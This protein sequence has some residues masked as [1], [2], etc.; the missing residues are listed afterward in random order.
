MAG[1]Y[2]KTQQD[3]QA[4]GPFTTDQLKALAARGK[5]KPHHL[6]SKDQKKWY[7]VKN[8]RGLLAPQGAAAGAA[9]AA[10]P[11]LPQDSD[12]VEMAPAQAVPSDGEARAV[13]AARRVAP[14]RRRARK[15]PPVA[16]LTTLGC[17]LIVGVIVG[18][19]L[20]FGRG[21]SNGDAS[22]DEPAAPDK[23]GANK[24]APDKGGTTTKSAPVP[25]A[26][27]PPAT[28]PPATTPPA[29][30]PPA[31]TPPA[32]TP[33]ATTPPATTPPAT[34]PP[35]T[36]PPATTPPATTPPVP[37]PPV[38]LPEPGTK[39]EPK[40]PPASLALL[41]VTYGGQEVQA[42]G[43]QLIFAFTNRCGRGI[44]SVKGHIRLY[45]TAGNYLIGLPTEIDEPVAAGA[46]LQKR[47][48]W[49]TL[50]GRLLEMLERSGKQMKFKFAADQVTY[51]DGKTVTF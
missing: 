15:R 39:T 13:P 4:Q 45:D 28:T 14:R 22:G 17:F 34:T 8:V 12:I 46:T 23:A 3:G 9:A 10:P 21:D 38:P 19:Y 37:S 43:S 16:L 27:T 7:V 41:S 26:T 32:T 33:P 25:P 36:T 24:G 18:G 30:T 20:L 51:N 35:A 44:K 47:K 11:S 42:M 6:I 31:T 2:V 5:L 48:V 1:Y 29:T 49:L 40:K 50:D